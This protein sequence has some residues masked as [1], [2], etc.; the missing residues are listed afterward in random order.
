[1]SKKSDRSRYYW[2]KLDYRRFEGDGDLNF[3]M[4]QKDG[5]QYVVLYMLLCLN[6]RNTDG[7]F[8][9]KMGE[10]SMPY[11]VERIVRECKFFTRKTVEKA[12]DFYKK[13]GLVYTNENGNLQI[14]DFKDVVG[15]ENVSAKRVRAYREK[16]KEDS[17]SADSE[18]SGEAKALHC[19]ADC[20][21]VCN[22]LVT[23]D[24]TIEIRDKNKEECVSS[25][26]SDNTEEE[27]TSHRSSCSSS[28][29]PSSHRTE[30]VDG[31]EQ[32]GLF[33]FTT[34]KNDSEASGQSGA[35]PTLEPEVM[36][37]D[38]GRKRKVKTKDD[39]R[40]EFPVDFVTGEIVNVWNCSV[41][42]AK[43]L[44]PS[45][46]AFLEM[47][48]S[49]KKPLIPSSFASWL[50]RGWKKADGD[51]TL[52]RDMVEESTA[53]S[54]QGL[55]LP[56]DEEGRTDRRARWNRVATN[57]ELDA[58]MERIR[59]NPHYKGGGDITNLVVEGLI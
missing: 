49:I 35:T 13:L 48:E 3:L 40:T 26:R 38:S 37:K 43:E 2:I 53:N 4:N 47:R 36:K 10:V 9:S 15:S 30:P 1:M 55:F 32:G 42:E 56:K 21:A 27:R 50:R 29:E 22:A 19:N 11:D 39:V 52:F 31:C 41:P 45:I 12:L 46:I 57:D 34:E 54:W 33:G 23:P 28:P 59:R 16:R 17:K 14:T 58:A 18:L 5:A 6:L 24:V 20:N 51:L 8:I 7:E 44:Y 25:L